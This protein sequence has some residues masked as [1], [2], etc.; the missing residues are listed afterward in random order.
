MVERGTR[1]TFGWYTQNG[2]TVIRRDVNGRGNVERVYAR[3]PGESDWRFVRQV[4]IKDAPE[5]AWIAP[6]VVFVPISILMTRHYR[7]KFKLD[8]PKPLAQSAPALSSSFCS[9]R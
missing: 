6:T 5:F 8:V 1:N 2:V 7:R 3:A 9:L 4:R